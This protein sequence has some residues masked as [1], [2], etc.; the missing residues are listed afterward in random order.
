M[1]AKAAGLVGVDINNPEVVLNVPA[2]GRVTR[3]FKIRNWTGKPRQWKAVA[4]APWIV[5]QRSSGT[6]LGFEDFGFTVD[7][8]SLTPGRTMKGHILVT[9]V[10]NGQKSKY[11]ITATVKPP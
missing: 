3:D 7:G 6:L 10:A 8:K 2:L 4:T 5:L 1:A 9:D 11:E